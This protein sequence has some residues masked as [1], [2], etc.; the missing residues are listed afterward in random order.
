MAVREFGYKGKMVSVDET[1]DDHADVTIEGRSFAFT[2]HDGALRLWRCEDA[3]LSSPELDKAV[4]HLV[5]YWYIVTDDENKAPPV[6]A[7]NGH[8][9]GGRAKAKPKRKPAR[10]S[11]GRS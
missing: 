2:R 8:R 3:Y 5:D 4:R 11:G 9:R 1:D 6:R 7:E 10:N